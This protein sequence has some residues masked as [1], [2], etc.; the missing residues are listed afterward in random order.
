MGFEDVRKVAACVLGHRLILDYSARLEGWTT[1]D[2]VE[3]LLEAVPEMSAEM[4]E[5]LSG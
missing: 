4:P 3:T 5:D 1:V 2:M